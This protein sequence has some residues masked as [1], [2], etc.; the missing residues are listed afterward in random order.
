M[1]TT[2]RPRTLGL[3]AALLI[4]AVAFSTFSASSGLG[5][6][7]QANFDKIREGMSSA[8]VEVLLGRENRMAIMVTDCVGHGSMG[9]RPCR[10]VAELYRG[11]AEPWDPSQRT[12][13]VEFQGDKVTRKDFTAAPCTFWEVLRDWSRRVGTRFGL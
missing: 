9:S 10:T 8:E 5:Q 11:R 3:V 12:D 1:S 7:T 2:L 13:R 6:V 4:G